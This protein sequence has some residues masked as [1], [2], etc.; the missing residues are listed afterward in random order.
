[1]KFTRANYQRVPFN[2]RSVRFRS[3]IPQKGAQNQSFN[4][5]YSPYLPA[6]SERDYLFEPPL[7]NA[8]AFPKD[9]KPYWRGSISLRRVCESA[10]TKCW[11]SRDRFG[12][13]GFR[14]N[15]FWTRARSVV[16]RQMKMSLRWWIPTRRI[17]KIVSLKI[18]ICT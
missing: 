1:M 13:N 4:L 3:S 15:V 16:A 6:S 2:G 11:Y 5:D 7:L 10:C 8:N 18:K 17:L 14:N 12:Y 9:F